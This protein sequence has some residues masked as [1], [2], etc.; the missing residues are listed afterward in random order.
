M[1]KS[2]ELQKKLVGFLPIGVF[3][4]IQCLLAAHERI[5]SKHPLFKAQSN[6]V[7][8]FIGGEIGLFGKIEY[9]KI[10]GEGHKTFYSR[11]QY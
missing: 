9:S 6:Q 5:F 7:Q 3:D 2:K 11:C 4:R 8:V 1:H 10:L